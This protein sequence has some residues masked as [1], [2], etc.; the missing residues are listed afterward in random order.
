VTALNASLSFFEVSK[1]AFLFDITDKNKPL[2][3]KE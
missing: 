3:L 1:L 2:S